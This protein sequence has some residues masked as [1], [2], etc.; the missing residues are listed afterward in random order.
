ME[1]NGLTNWSD[2]FNEINP[3]TGYPRPSPRR[4]TWDLPQEFHYTTWNAERSIAAI[5][6]A[7]GEN[8]P[9]FLWASFHDPHPPYLVPQPWAIMYDSD[10][11]EIGRPLD[12]PLSPGELDAMPPHYALTQ[13]DRPDFSAWRET[14]FANHGFHSHRV[15]EQTMK[16]NIA[17]YYGMIS[18]MDQQIGRILERLDEL[19][20]ADNTLVVFSTDHGHFFWGSTV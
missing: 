10:E 11:M 13:Q 14:P 19:G 16:K 12:P 15:N 3:D 6:R 8:W 7:H 9:F 17:V 5:E 4:H 20:L 18:F 2:Y 1:G